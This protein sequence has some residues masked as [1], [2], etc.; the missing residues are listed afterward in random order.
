MGQYRTV[1]QEVKFSFIDQDTTIQTMQANISHRY[2]FS[3]VVNE[4]NGSLP[5]SLS[6]S[7]ETGPINFI[8]LAAQNDF[9]LTIDSSKV[10]TVKEFTMIQTSQ[11]FT[12]RIQ[13][14]VSGEC[15]LVFHYF[16]GLISS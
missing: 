8:F 2:D 3:N 14:L 4:R 6:E 11:T 13:P 16:H 12:A 9:K 1:R 15:T 5:L 10:F 7:Y